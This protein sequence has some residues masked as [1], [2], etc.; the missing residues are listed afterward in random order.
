MWDDLQYLYPYGQTATTDTIGIAKNSYKCL[1][2]F[3]I[4]RLQGLK[5]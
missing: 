5:R 2:N 3:V 4:E 1:L